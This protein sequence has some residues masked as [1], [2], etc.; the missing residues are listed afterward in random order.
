[1]QKFQE[2]GTKNIRHIWSV[3]CGSSIVDQDTNNMTLNNLIEEVTVT[4]GKE[5]VEA[6]E[7]NKTR[8]YAIPAQMWLVTRFMRK[9]QSALSFDIRFE[10]LN[11]KGEV[12]STLNQSAVEVKKGITNLRIRTMISPLL[13]DM[14]GGYTIQVSIRDSV[15]PNF[16]VVD[17][18]PLLVKINEAQVSN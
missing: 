4:V 17:R 13:V 11:P 18:V 15:E 12:L 6:K 2:V 9:S 5:Q 3:L 14:E 1:M 8:G 10:L 16:I 7:K